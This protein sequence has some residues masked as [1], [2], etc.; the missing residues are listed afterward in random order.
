MDKIKLVEKAKEG[1]KEALIR[2]I[3]DQ[4]QDYYK[5]AYVY[6]KNEEDA[7]DAMEDMIVILYESIHKLKNC[8]VFYSWSKTILVNCCK[9]NLRKRKRIV[10][11]E[12]IKEKD[13]DK[14]VEDKLIEDKNNEIMLE[15]HLSKLSANHQEVIKLR[16]FLD[17]D[18]ETIAKLIKVPI[19]TVKSRISI[20]IK[21]LRAS[22]GGEE[23]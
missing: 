18:Y 16:Y 17:L 11:L 15:N 1:D 19:G 6:M 7:L 22:L 2:L 9:K 20:G 12:D 23:F 10:S 5:L 4:K 14:V 8:D 13:K 3:M 21:K